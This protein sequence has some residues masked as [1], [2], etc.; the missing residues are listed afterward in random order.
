[1]LSC[2]ELIWLLSCDAKLASS[3]SCDGFTSL[4]TI[5]SLGKTNCRSNSLLN[6]ESSMS[7]LTTVLDTLKQ[8]TWQTARAQ[9]L[10][11]TRD[12]PHSFFDR[13]LTSWCTKSLGRAAKRPY[14]PCPRFYC[15]SVRCLNG[16]DSHR[17]HT[18]CSIGR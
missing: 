18:F 6:W 3:A 15:R 10:H 5:S 12:L 11:T 13:V 4:H 17:V 14:D 7:V 8:T 2:R 16:I 1:M 9:A